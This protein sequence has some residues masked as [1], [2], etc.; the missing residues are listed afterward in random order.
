MRDGGGEMCGGRATVRV[1]RAA[2]VTGAAATA[3]AAAAGELLRL[4][5]YFSRLQVAA[6]ET[7]TALDTHRFSLATDGLAL[8]HQKPLDYSADRFSV[9]IKHASSG[10][11]SKADAVLRAQSTL[12]SHSSAVS[13]TLALFRS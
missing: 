13:S 3:A 7:Y 1:R 2:A 5:T 10:T 4:L 12:F 8:P 11:N 9:R 6:R